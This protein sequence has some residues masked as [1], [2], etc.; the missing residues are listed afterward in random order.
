MSEPHEQRPLNRLE[1][2]R[3]LK[4]ANIDVVFATLWIALAG[5]AFQTGFARSLGANDFWLGFLSATPALVGLAQI[6]AAAWGDRYPSRRQFVIPGALALR[7]LWF[8]VVL[9]AFFV[10]PEP[11]LVQ[12]SIP[13]ALFAFFVTASA[14]ASSIITP[15]WTAWFSD[16]VPEDH[17]GRYFANRNA[18]LS[19]ANIAVAI[20]AA[21][22]LDLSVKHGRFSP[23]VAFGSLFLLG[24]ICL[25]VSFAAILKQ[26]EQAP[27][28]P[29]ERRDWR[30]TLIA[31]K[32]PFADLQ[33]RR[34]IWFYALFTA[35]T[36]FPGQFFTVYMLENLGMSYVMVQ[37]IMTVSSIFSVLSLK[38]WGYLGDKYGNKPLLIIAGVGVCIW[39]LAW[40]LTT[41]GDVVRSLVVLIVLHVFTG[42]SW[43]CVNLSQFNLMLSLTREDQRTIYLGTISAVTGVAGGIS[44][45]I[46]GMFVSAMH[47]L[48]DRPEHSFFAL[49]V[50]TALMR[51][52]SLIPLSGI[53][54]PRGATIRFVLSQIG[55]SRPSGWL[56]LSRFS[57]SRSE[58]TRASAAQ[59]LGESRMPIAVEELI[60]ALDDPSYAVR[61]TAAVA[62]GRIGDRRAVEALVG[63]LDD[64][65]ANIGVEAAEALGEIGDP[66]ATTALIEELRNPDP[67]VSQAAAAA[68]GKIGSPDS[69]EP[70]TRMAR[71]ASYPGQKVMALR[72]LR[73]I[74]GAQTA[75]DAVA[76]LL[77]APE[78][79]LRSTAAGTLRSLGVREAAPAVRAQM[80]AD[81]DPL[82]LGSLA[83]TLGTLGESADAELLLK[84]AAKA[85]S[86]LARKRILL[87]LAAL[88][89]VEAAFYG[90]LSR[91]DLNRDTAVIQALEPRAR[92]DSLF[93]SALNAYAAADY[94][95]AVGHICRARPGNRELQ[96]LASALGDSARLEHMLLAVAV[97]TNTE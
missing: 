15:A 9:L 82:S 31:F 22:F 1:I 58:D 2:L 79:Y 29:R 25:F 36:V 52:V 71:D 48:F 33:F 96:M 28:A 19:A 54:D 93:A 75:A 68:L 53:R 59:T 45:L 5:G 62:L 39:P 57:R 32:Q 21:W 60:H 61:V 26:P 90:L 84:T 10:K 66:S 88:W 44:P 50:V 97:L 18:L 92:K 14:L 16:L 6:P 86:P 17:R 55:S 3:G 63:K 78:P 77:S 41:P 76:E 35:A 49:F 30:Q 27:A 89:N 43:A 40:L 95:E 85:D 46:G 65:V 94:R 12:F 64:G 74:P 80:Q 4:I 69:L 23:Q 8:P 7:L 37:V 24:F 67:R 56:A 72:A 81:D 20:P 70:L 38:W 51:A 91:V 11:H 73:T 42:V 34:M 83:Y 47:G 87:G 13:L